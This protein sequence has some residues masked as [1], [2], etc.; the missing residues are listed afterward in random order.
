VAK[1]LPLAA[2]I[3]D[4]LTGE[5]L[6]PLLAPAGGV[7]VI[8]L[9]GLL[10]LRIT[11]SSGVPSVLAMIALGWNPVFVTAVLRGNPSVALLGLLF[12]SG[13][14]GRRWQLPIAVALP[15]VRPEGL[16]FSIW[17]LVRGRRF[18]L[19]PLL[20][21]PVAVWPLLNR[22][23]AGYWLWS[24]EAVR[25]VVA[26]MAYPTP[27]IVSFW[28][29]AV[30]R[31]LATLGPVLAAAM[32]LEGRKRWAWGPAVLANML[33]LWLSLAGGSLVLPRYLDHVFLLMVPSAAAAA[34]TLAGPGRKAV[35]A[36]SALAVACILAGWPWAARDLAW[37]ARLDLELRMQAREGWSGRLAVNELLVPAI[38]LEAGTED[39]SGRF[40]ALDRAAWEGIGADSLASLGVD[41]ILVVDHPPYLPYHTRSYLEGL[42]G[43]RIDTLMTEER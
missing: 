20:L 2:A 42:G 1:P 11:G 33:F 29:W 18:A 37:H 39:P 16:V 34:A 30:L 4:A 32:L 17:L 14:L 43:I 26:A 19:L 25:Y 31:G 21:L 12:A 9:A 5:R 6:M 7:A 10:A 40:L 38:A 3:L 41:R 22:L 15:L 24:M 23:T 13:I 28:P 35:L 36:V 8:L 27:G